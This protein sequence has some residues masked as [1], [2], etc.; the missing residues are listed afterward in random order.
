M[1][2]NAEILF[3][4][5][6]SKFWIHIAVILIAGYIYWLKK[7]P[8]EN[9]DPVNIGFV[10]CFLA[11]WPFSL[12]LGGFILICVAVFAVPLLLV[13]GIGKLIKKITVKV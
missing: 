10:V 1:L 11:G 6:A 9:R 7:H 12:L 13:A 8:K 5:A 3:Q 4:I 2:E